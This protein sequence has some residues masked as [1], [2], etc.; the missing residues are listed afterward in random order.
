MSLSL[1]ALVAVF[2]GPVIG[3]T[4]HALDPAAASSDG[5]AAQNPLG[6]AI[7]CGVLFGLVLA[8]IRIRTGPRE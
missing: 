7:V 1:P 6:L 4:A 5:G 8:V 3:I 2:G